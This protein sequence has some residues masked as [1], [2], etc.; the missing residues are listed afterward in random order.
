VKF[1]RQLA[2]TPQMRNVLGAELNHSLARSDDDE[3]RHDIRQRSATVYHPCG[4]CAMGSDPQSS[5]LDPDLRV[6]GVSGLRVV[7]ASAFPNILSGNIN[8]PVMLLASLAAER[9]VRATQS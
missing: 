5:V 6:R 4:T 2:A 3:L 9:I 1:I 7:D 8:V